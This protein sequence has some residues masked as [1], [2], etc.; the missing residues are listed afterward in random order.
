MQAV[1]SSNKLVPFR[2]LMRNKIHTFL[3]AKNAQ[4]DAHKLMQQP[5]YLLITYVNKATPGTF[6]TL[7]AYLGSLLVTTALIAFV[8]RPG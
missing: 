2:A 8:Y 7:A 5:V 1:L 3:H 4:L 6:I